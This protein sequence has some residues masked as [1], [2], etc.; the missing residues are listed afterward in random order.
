M[1]RYKLTDIELVAKASTADDNANLFGKAFWNAFSKNNK[2][3]FDIC[4]YISDV[5]KLVECYDD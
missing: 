4:D 5:A 3:K 1:R 2:L